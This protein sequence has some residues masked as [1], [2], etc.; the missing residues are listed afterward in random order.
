MFEDPGPTGVSGG[1]PRRL[2]SSLMQLVRHPTRGLPR[3]VVVLGVVSFFADV[4][5][6]MVYP[7]IPLFITGTL[8]A[9]AAVLGL[10]EGL[11]EGTASLL[12][13]AS[14]AISDRTSRRVP[15]VAGGYGLSALGKVLLGAAMAWPFALLARLV[16]RTGKGFRGSPR[17]ALIADS[18]LPGERGR[19]FGFHRS[20]DTADAVVGPL[21]GLGLVALFDDRLRPVFFIAA[22]PG[23]LSVL[24]L[25]AVREG[26]R[27]R[28]VSAALATEAAATVSLEAAERSRGALTPP[29]IALFIALG[30]F[31]IGNS[32]DVF[33][34]LR[35][36]DL[37]LSTTSVVL[38]YVVYNFVY[39]ATAYP[40]G[41]LS[42]RVPRQVVLQGG[43]LVFAAVY[44]GFALTDS[45]NAIWVLMAL[46]GLYIAATDGVARA[47]VVDFAPPEWRATALGWHGMIVGL[48]AIGSSLV[49]GIL[50]DQVGSWAPF[51][52]G[53]TAAL[54]GAVLLLAV[55]GDGGKSHVFGG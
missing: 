42:D 10:I 40:L 44:A 24:A 55:R 33:I 29:L 35:A 54:A 23:A 13:L 2:R 27:A 7:L 22:I 20:M 46:Y 4:S 47:L 1:A 41:I 8:G 6:E 45:V 31:A 21:L 50:W 30:A 36:R 17:D 48:A 9:P 53:A 37:G 12:K 18:A 26:A 28:S 32:S 51:A 14:G 15:L 52:L 16:D 39:M 25:A 43:L 34:L 5:S 19:S 38:V 49:A 11:A 3:N